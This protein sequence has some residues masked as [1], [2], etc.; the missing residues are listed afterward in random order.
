M[1]NDKIIIK[2]GRSVLLMW[3][4]AGAQEPLYAFPPSFTF[5]QANAT[6]RIG[7]TLGALRADP[8]YASQSWT[9]NDATLSMKVQGVQIWT[10]PQTAIYTFIVV[11]AQGSR[12]FGSRGGF[13]AAVN[14]TVKL[15]EC[16]HVYIVVGQP[17]QSA[18]ANAGGGG[19]SFVFSNDG[20]LLF[21]AGGG[22]GPVLDTCIAK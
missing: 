3:S 18:S 22:G 7:P 12:T 9:Q 4:Y 6:G 1:P 8:G 2:L 17:G 10:V 11:G 5:T 20:A 13:G 15:F 16:D 19:G 21:A 14:A